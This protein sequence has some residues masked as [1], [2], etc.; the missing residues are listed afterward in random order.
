LITTDR[1]QWERKSI[2]LSRR[3]FMKRKSRRFKDFENSKSEL[4][5]DNQKLMRL[6]Q[7]ELLKKVR[8]KKDLKRSEN[9]NIRLK[10]SKK[11]LRQ[12]RNNSRRKS[13][14]SPNKQNKSEM[15]FWESS[16]SK[17]RKE[18]EK[19][20]LRLRRRR[21]W[22]TTLNNWDHRSNRMKKSRSKTDLITLRKE[23]LFDKS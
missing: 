12:E 23:E 18:R 4:P 16:S 2:L 5:T 13:D 7:S 9:K 17:K 21:S 1:R 22:T 19:L 3:E 11:W 14:F 15:S 8:D 6:E 20:R 10:F